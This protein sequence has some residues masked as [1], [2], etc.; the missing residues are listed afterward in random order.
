[1]FDKPRPRLPVPLCLLRR[2][3]WFKQSDEKG[4]SCCTV[5][6]TLSKLTLKYP[7]TRRFRMP[8]ILAQGISGCA[9]LPSV[10]T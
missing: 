8:M 1:M 7:C 4:R 5:S 9:F 3:K 2:H 6:H 10:L